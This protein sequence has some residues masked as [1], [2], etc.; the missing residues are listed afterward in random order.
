MKACTKI[1]GGRFCGGEL[2]PGTFHWGST[3]PGLRHRAGRERGGIAE[4]TGGDGPPSADP[5]AAIAVPQASN[6]IRLPLPDD[7]DESPPLCA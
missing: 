4:E 6:A 3:P 5:S 1:V 7:E 2:E